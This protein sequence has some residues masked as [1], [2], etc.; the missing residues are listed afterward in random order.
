MCFNQPMSGAFV[1]LGLLAALFVWIKGK[2]VPFVVGILYFVAMEL[3]QFFQYFWIDECDNKIN[4]AL[5]VVG[6]L[7]ICFQPYFTHLMNGAFSR[8]A[9][10][11]AK[12]EL[13]RRL[14]IVQGIWM[15]AR[16]L[17]AP[18]TAPL[19]YTEWLRGDKLCTLTGKYHLSW[20]LPLLAPTYFT[21]SNAIHCFMMFAPFLV[22][23]PRYLLG[24]LV[25]FLTGPVLSALITPNLYE[26][27]AIWCFMSISQIVALVVITNIRTNGKW[28]PNAP[29]RP[30]APSFPKRAPIQKT[31]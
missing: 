15:F 10:T 27:A 3:L 9:E 23:G 6:F 5:T 2:N 31:D 16:F 13:V 29:V 17:L 12:F 25:L 30:K 18:E 19:E 7:H 20:S 4:Q 8:S 22:M 14:A 24:G 26:Q 21:P 1:V 11:K 28:D